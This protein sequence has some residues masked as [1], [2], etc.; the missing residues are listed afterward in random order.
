M[1]P[2]EELMALRRMAE[3]EAKASG[4]A[5]TVSPQSAPSPEIN[6]YED[7]AKTVGS[8][9]LQGALSIP[10]VIPD[11]MNQAV[12]GPQYLYEGIIGKDRKD[13]QPYKPFYGSEDVTSMM[14]L[15]YQPQTTAGKI[16]E[17]PA[18][19][20]GSLL[21]AKTVQKATPGVNRFLSD[22]GSGK[23]PPPPKKP[24][25]VGMEGLDVL[26]EAN[27]KVGF[28]RKKPNPLEVGIDVNQKISK[29]Y[30]ADTELQR[31]LY[32][33]LNAKGKKFS[34]KAPDLYNKLDDM[35]T[36]LEK[37]DIAPDTSEYRTLMDLKDF[38]DNLNQK[39]GISGT[40]DKTMQMPSWK[41]K[42]VVEKG[43]PGQAAYGIE[44]SDLVDLKTTINS[45]L[46]P[47]RFPKAG[48]AKI[49]QFKKY[50]QDSL[51]EA[52][53]V[54]PEFKRSLMAAE[55]QAARVG[56]Y[57]EDS[58][59]PLWQHEDYVA[60]KGGTPLQADT[61]NRAARLLDNLNSQVLGRSS[62]L[63]KILPKDDLK[64]IFRAA[65]LN[66]KGRKKLPFPT[67]TG[68]AKNTV[69]SILNPD[70]QPLQ[71]IARHLA[72]MQKIPTTAPT[73]AYPK[74]L[75]YGTIA[76]MLSNLNQ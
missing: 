57:K 36:H 40:P 69:D 5:Q 52:G 73:Q 2:R 53:G 39:Y 17:I 30:G 44:P 67:K 64:K 50:V 4:G 38:R 45:G 74:N 27:K 1:D 56:I 23:P 41:Q 47:N 49:M 25:P 15:D 55:K 26:P 46:K 71:E 62:S 33:D 9:G 63:S 16:S 12:A 66:A 34:L 59:K 65:I 76:A 6:A 54:S 8:K 22:T 35:V 72:E 18:I 60:W 11:L 70:T 28:M 51:N 19:I 75:E 37:Y 14:G 32:A 48:D 42:M 13:F 61:Q 58:L 10:M 43:T 3:L 68:V 24:L 20:G 29:Q 21:G 31:N 7:V